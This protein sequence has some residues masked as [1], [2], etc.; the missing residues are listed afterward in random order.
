MMERFAILIHFDNL[1]IP[2]SPMS[3]MEFWQETEI[4]GR[5]IRKKKDLKFKMRMFDTTIVS[6]VQR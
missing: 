1:S 4:Q 6:G 3:K 5:L 2:E